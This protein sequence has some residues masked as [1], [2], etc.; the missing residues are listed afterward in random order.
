MT[1]KI[2]P[3]CSFKKIYDI[4]RGKCRCKRCKYEWVPHRLPLYLNRREWIKILKWF[5][6]GISSK[7]IS[8]ETGINRQRVLRA[9]LIVREVMSKDIPEV[10]SGTVE[11]DETYIG[12]QW[13]NKR[14]SQKKGQ[15]KRGCRIPLKMD[16]QSH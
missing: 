7:E 9:L 6:H 14:R 13:K 1:K 16:P 4:R 12:G 15:T 10:F 3:K 8:K 11:V 5:L 2:C